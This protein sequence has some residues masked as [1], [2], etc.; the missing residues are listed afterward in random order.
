[1]FRQHG[2]EQQ[3]DGAVPL[4]TRS[5]HRSSGGL[6]VGATLYR[7]RKQY[8]KVRHKIKIEIEN[9]FDTAEMLI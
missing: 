6:G 2:T 9:K 8:T 7:A 3:A 1:M 4:Q 5:P